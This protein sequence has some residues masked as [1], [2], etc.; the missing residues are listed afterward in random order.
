[1]DGAFREIELTLLRQMSPEQKLRTL[2]A[3]RRTASLLA[4]AG[5]RMRQPDLPPDEV[6]REARRILGLGPS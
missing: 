6:R 1:M 4:E 5:V 2:D 3:L